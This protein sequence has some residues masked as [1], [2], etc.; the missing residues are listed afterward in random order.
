MNNKYIEY[1]HSGKGFPDTVTKEIKKKKAGD[2]IVRVD[3][4][5]SLWADGVYRIPPRLLLQPSP[6]Y[7]LGGTASKH[8]IQSLLHAIE[9]DQLMRRRRLN[10]E[11]YRSKDDIVAARLGKPMA[12]V[13]LVCWS[14]G[15]KNCPS[16][17]GLQVNIILSCRQSCKSSNIRISASVPDS[18]IS[19][20]Q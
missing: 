12:M 13:Y 3:V 15:E 2:L 16:K 8:S 7:L 20:V 10:E 19:F 1:R 18:F 14:T 5:A 11:Y 9:H 17:N 6:L 4:S